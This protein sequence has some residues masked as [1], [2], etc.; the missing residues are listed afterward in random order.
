MAKRKL[1][2]LLLEESSITQSQMEIVT[3]CRSASRKIEAFLITR[4]LGFDSHVCDKHFQNK[5]RGTGNFL[6]ERE[7]NAR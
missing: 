2:I 3:P 6:G 5:R 7:A 4:R 1:E